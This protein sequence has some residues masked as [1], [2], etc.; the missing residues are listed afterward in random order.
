MYELDSR[1]VGGVEAAPNS[2]P[3]QVA[4][5]IDAQYFCGGK[6]KFEFL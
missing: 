4:L 1:I 5:N 6:I 2:V 3:H